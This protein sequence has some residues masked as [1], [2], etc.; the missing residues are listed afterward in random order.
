MGN[1]RLKAPGRQNGGT[2]M[3]LFRAIERVFDLNF[4]FDLAAS[5]ENAK[6]ERFYTIEDDALAQDW[7]GLASRVCRPYSRDALWLNCPFNRT[8]AFAAKCAEHRH[9]P[10][11]LLSL[12]SVGA[13]YYREHLE[14]HAYVR[15]LTT[16]PKF[17]GYAGSGAHDIMLSFFGATRPT[18]GQHGHTWEWKADL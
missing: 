5:V 2:P 3:E 12:A 14:P 6:C 17:E 8:T 10:I 16:R 11:V 13:V 18:D 15:F 7:T 9:A 4:V 1:A